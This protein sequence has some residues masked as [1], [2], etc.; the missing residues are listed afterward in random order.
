[1]AHLAIAG[2]KPVRTAPFPR[3]NPLGAEEEAAAAR[4]VRSGKLSEFVGKDNAMFLGGDEV[5]AFEEEWAAYC[6][7]R[8]AVSMNS[9]TSAL[10]AAIGAIEAGPGDEIIVSAYSHCCS[11]TVPLLYNAIPVFADLEME[12]YCFDLA[13]VERKITPRTRAILSV[14]LFGQS[15]DMDGLRELAQRHK[16]ALISD[17]AH[18]PGAAYHGRK[19]GTLADIGVYSLNGHKIIHTGEGGV[20]VT[21]NAELA[22]RLRRIRNHAEA[23]VGSQ[24][25][26][27]II[28]MLGQ[29]YRLPEIEAAIGREQLRKLPG[30]LRQ[31]Q[32]LAEY[33]TAGLRQLPGLVPPAVRPDSTHVYYLYPVRY[34]AAAVGLTRAQ[35]LRA[36]NA[37]G[38][39]LYSMAGGYVQPLYWEPLFAERTMY[40]KGCP[41]TCQHYGNDISYPRGLCPNVEALHEREL[42]VMSYIYPPLTSAD[43]DDIITAFRK[44]LDHPEEA[45]RD[46]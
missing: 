28:N 35:L 40:Q 36:V 15:A 12:Y 32:D 39:P 25:P 7:V 45:R 3:Y 42:I 37:E 17:A 9:A 33:L 14:D 1:M 18:V 16:L 22:Q 2:G 4:V 29:N 13:D 8:Y 5:R 44:V 10:F 30:L 6:G 31:R 24:R 34:D 11:A 21:D 23:V 46:A 19:A 38:I 41:F 43:M 27:S 26:A 20:A